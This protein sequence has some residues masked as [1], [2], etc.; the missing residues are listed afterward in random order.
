MGPT[1]CYRKR[2]QHSVMKDGTAFCYSERE[3]H[4]VTDGL[5]DKESL[6][7]ESGHSASIGFTGLQG[8]FI[9]FFTQCG[10]YLHLHMAVESVCELP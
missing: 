5:W 8:Q 2:E 6:I 4:S 3:E 7:S 1:F 10:P 9:D